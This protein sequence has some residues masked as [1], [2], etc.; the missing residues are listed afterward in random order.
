LITE[1]RYKIPKAV[2][3]HFAGLRS[4]V[5]SPFWGQ[6]ATSFIPEDVVIVTRGIITFVRVEEC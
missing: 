5:T 1:R 4:N 2:V 3:L 6:I